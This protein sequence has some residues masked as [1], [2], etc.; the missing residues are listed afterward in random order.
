[1]SRLFKL[2]ER[3]ARR[4]LCLFGPLKRGARRPFCQS[5]QA[6]KP[7]ESVGRPFDKPWKA[8]A[9]C[10]RATDKSGGRL[11]RVVEWLKAL[12]GHWRASLTWFP[13]AHGSLARSC[14]KLR[15]KDKPENRGAWL[16]CAEY[17]VVIDDAR[18]W[19]GGSGSVYDSERMRSSHKIWWASGALSGVIFGRSAVFAG[20]RSSVNA[21]KIHCSPRYSLAK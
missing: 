18:R 10:F 9:P 19:P 7:C 12:E 13:G 6:N 15:E 21:S 16:P 2:L 17:R 11:A 14:A 1:M 4:P 20:P 8:S 3:G 5:K